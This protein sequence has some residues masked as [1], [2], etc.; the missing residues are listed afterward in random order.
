LILAK[1]V[2]FEPFRR[3]PA[4]AIVEIPFKIRGF[5]SVLQTASMSERLTISF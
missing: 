2:H 4:Q 1:K 3:P 5:L